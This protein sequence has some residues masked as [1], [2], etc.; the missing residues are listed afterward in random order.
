MR[1]EI[2]PIVSDLTDAEVELVQPP[3]NLAC[4]TEQIWARTRLTTSTTTE[5]V[6]MMGV[7]SQADESSGPAEPNLIRIKRPKT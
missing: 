2:I 4:H 3:N 5:R 6:G 1:T 7:K